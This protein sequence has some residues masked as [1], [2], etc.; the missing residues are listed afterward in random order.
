[1][2]HNRMITSEHRIQRAVEL[3]VFVCVSSV[4]SAAE[5]PQTGTRFQESV[6]DGCSDLA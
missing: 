1:M 6:G 3:T 5:P 2:W 4:A